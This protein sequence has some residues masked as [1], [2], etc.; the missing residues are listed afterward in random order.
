V[1]AVA[2]RGEAAGRG[3]LKNVMVGMFG[4]VR[5]RTV[6]ADYLNYDGAIFASFK[7]A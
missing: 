5:H 4:Y 7:F 6:Q 1:L 2:K 3:V